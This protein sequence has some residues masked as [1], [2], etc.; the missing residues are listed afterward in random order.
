MNLSNRISRRTLLRG[1]GAA[2]ALPFLDAMVAPFVRGAAEKMTPTRTAFLYVP[3][4]MTME[5]WEPA[6]DGVG[7]SAIPDELPLIS[8]LL[9]PH[10]GDVTLISHLACANA[11]SLGDGGGDHG[12]AG[13]N[14]LTGAHPKKTAGRDIHVG[15]S[16]DQIAA[17][18]L[19]NSTRFGSL[20][21][22]CEEGL[23]GGGC[24]TGYSCAYTN[25][26]AWRTPTTPMPPEIRP[27]A[28]FERLFGSADQERDPVKRKRQELYQRSIL[29]TVLADANRLR[30]S[31][32]SSDRH[33]LDEY[34]FDI[35]DLETRIQKVEKNNAQ[36]P[37]DFAVPSASVP[38]DFAEHAH[39]MFDLMLLAFQMDMTR[40]V[41]MMLS[42]EVSYR[43]YG[44]EIGI[45][46]A[47]HGLTHH[48]GDKVKIE[49][50]TRINEYHMQQFIKLLDKMKAIKEG[51]G[52]LLDHSM[53]SYG[54][55]MGD[56]NRHDHN[57]IPLVIAGKANGKLRPGR[58]IR[59]KEG[60][61]L[62][63]LHLTMLDKMGLQSPQSIGDSTG[64]LE[65]V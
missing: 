7:V 34:L 12:R 9:L 21:M 52:T 44:A 30:T 56:G 38:S 65:E 8:Q 53:I 17:Q 43:A 2:V 41:T 31:L 36:A 19:A 40:M 24:D 55:A 27:R 26:L 29:D 37:P 49:K 42:V 6:I 28:M 61:P 50:V 14:Y 48:G 45:T 25:N 13:A 22:G 4:G 15:V 23:Q 46:E 58:H 47:H 54:S 35:R 18:Q 39:L 5:Q 57:H 32:G 51:D 59:Y 64:L 60:T 11:N 63:N 20:E 16:I 3:N 62:S 10:R 33:K 1:T